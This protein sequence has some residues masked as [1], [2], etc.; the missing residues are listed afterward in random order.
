MLLQIFIT[1]IL[2]ISWMKESLTDQQTTQEIIINQ[3]NSASHKNIT[4]PHEQQVYRYIMKNYELCVRPL[5]NISEKLIVKLYIRLQQISGLNERNQVLTTIMFLE[6]I[7]EDVYLKWN[8]TEFGNVRTLRIPAKQIWTP[9][10]YVF[11]NADHIN[12]GFLEGIYVLVHSSGKVTW[13]IPVQLKTSCKVDITLFPFDYQN[14]EIQ[15]G[16]WI[17]QSDWIEYQFETQSLQENSTTTTSS[18]SSYRMNHSEEEFNNDEVNNG[19][20]NEDYLTKHALDTSSYWDSSDWMLL[21][22]SLAYTYRSTDSLTVWK[23]TTTT[24]VLNIE[25]NSNKIETLKHTKKQTDLVLK[26]YLQRRSFFYIWNI[27][28]PCI[29]LTMLTLVTFWTPVVSGEKVTLGLSVFLAFSMFM[30]LIAERVP[31]T[32]KSIPLIGVYMTSVMTLTVGSVVACVIV[33]NLDSR[34][35]KLTRAPKFLRRLIQTRLIRMFYKYDN[36][37]KSAVVSSI[38]EK[39][40]ISTTSQE[41]KLAK[42]NCQISALCELN[43]LLSKDE[44][45]TKEIQSIYQDYLCISDFMNGSDE[46]KKKKKTSPVHSLDS[47]YNDQDVPVEK[48]MNHTVTSPQTMSASFLES[49]SIRMSSQ[50]EVNKL[51]NY[52][53]LS[54]IRDSTELL[55]TDFDVHGDVPVTPSGNNYATSTNIDEKIDHN[56][57][58]VGDQQKVRHELIKYEW[59]LIAKIT[60]RLLFI[61]FVLITIICYVTIFVWPLLCGPSY[62][63]HHHYHH[64][65]HRNSQKID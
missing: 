40:S 5:K 45:L 20:I 48:P 35:E 49:S 47:I 28:V 54:I 30:M 2:V 53:P 52:L 46:L 24:T 38:I 10:T 62:Q 64:H 9:D 16:S 42:I 65:R 32:A 22:A 26:L 18:S 12:S 41:N 19:I 15:F 51:A 13:S 61:T 6:Q 1:S 21:H 50:R 7:W 25:Q 17:Y 63:H 11:N 44:Q 34:G 60:D 33:I 37:N 23:P 8:E 55:S 43:Q 39:L 56:E 59:K 57:A 14:C 36:I 3:T 58:N 29:L 27:V 4:I 31:P